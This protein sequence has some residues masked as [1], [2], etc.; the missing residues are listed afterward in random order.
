MVRASYFRENESIVTAATGVPSVALLPGL[1]PAWAI[2]VTTS[3]P[4]VTLPTTVYPPAES[5]E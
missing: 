3:M 2:F 4:L 5:G 1:I